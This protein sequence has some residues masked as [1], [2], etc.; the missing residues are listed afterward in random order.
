MPRPWDADPSAEFRRR[1]GPA[2]LSLGVTKAGPDCPDMWELDN[3]DIAVIGRDA[4]D[5]YRGRLPDGVSV[6]ADERLVV[7]PRVTLTAAKP[8]IPDA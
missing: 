2:P 6:G 3:G 5:A 7:I 8:E 1:I 4:T